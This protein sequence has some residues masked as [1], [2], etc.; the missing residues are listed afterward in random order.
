ML[1]FATFIAFDLE[2]TGLDPARNKIIEVAGVKFTIELKNG[3]LV[4]KTIGTFSSLV[5]P[6]MHI[7]AEATQVN[8]ICDAD[9]DDAPSITDV[10]PEFTKFLRHQ[11][12]FSC[13]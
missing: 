13:S 6:T 11:H 8:G 1:P 2:T 10:L 9:V 12:Y 3:I 4:P 5:K 7:P